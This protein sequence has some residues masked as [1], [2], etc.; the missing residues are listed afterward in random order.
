MNIRKTKSTLAILSLTALML[1]AL[2][3]NAAAITLTNQGFETGDLTGWNS[4]GSVNAT[5]STSVTTY[6]SIT[7]NILAADTNMGYLVS[8]GASE[9]QIET[10]LGI[11]AGTLNALNTNPNGGNLTNGSAISQIFSGNIGDTISMYYNYVAT[12]YTPFNDPSFAVIVAPDNSAF[13]NVLASTHGLGIPVGTAGNSGWNLFQY[14]L[15]QVGNYTIGFVTTNDKDT[16][17]N[18]HLFLDNKA[19]SCEP[20]CQTQ[21]VPEPASLALFG[22]GIAGLAA[23]RRRKIGMCV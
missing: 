13:I 19:G 7:Y 3:A 23:V 17:L 16:I 4:L 6:N 8:S 21:T 5:P 15:T 22:I 9:A 18:S 11:G 10:F 14:T 1:P 20:A 12:D 2:N